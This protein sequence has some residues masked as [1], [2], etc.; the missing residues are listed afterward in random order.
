[1]TSIAKAELK[2][3]AEVIASLR[4]AG[5]E[6]EKAVEEY[7]AGLAGLAEKVATAL[8]PY[9]EALQEAAEFR[10]Q[11]VCDMEMYADDKSERWQESENGEA[12][13]AWMDSWRECELGEIELE[14][15]EQIE[16]PDLSAADQFDDLGD[17]P[18]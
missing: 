5:D 11:V 4:N 10:D 8:E 13:Q 7:N 18:E 16:T 6:L 2:R 1:M 14:L 12:Y 9:N 17:Q 3:K 15:P